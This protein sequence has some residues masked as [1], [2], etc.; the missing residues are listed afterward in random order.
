VS[1]LRSD[2]KDEGFIVVASI[3][4]LLDPALLL[5]IYAGD[6]ATNHDGQYALFILPILLLGLAALP[7]TSAGLLILAIWSVRI[8]SAA[9]GV[10]SGI[11]LFACLAAGLLCLQP[12]LA[13]RGH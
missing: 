3:V 8:R 6:G 7:I 11:G 9:A 1:K 4:C 12:F 10:S 5:A 13:S 2:R